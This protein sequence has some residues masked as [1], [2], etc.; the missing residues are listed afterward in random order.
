MSFTNS[1]QAYAV[2]NNYKKKIKELYPNIPDTSGIYFLVREDEDG[3][4]Y[5]Y[6]G[7]MSAEKFYNGIIQFEYA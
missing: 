6:V 4:K 1:K 2:I 7:Q 3:I 5:Y